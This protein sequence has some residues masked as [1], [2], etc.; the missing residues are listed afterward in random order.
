[1]SSKMEA[2]T[3]LKYQVLIWKFIGIIPSITQKSF[4]IA[5]F[6]HIIGDFLFLPTLI[7]GCTKA[8]NS[9]ELILGLAYAIP[10]LCVVF[11]VVST[12]F[13]YQQII[14]V[15]EILDCLHENSKEFKEEYESIESAIQKSQKLFKFICSFYYSSV[16]IMEIL[17]T[18]VLPGRNLMAPMWV[19]FIDWK[20]SLM[21]YGLANLFQYIGIMYQVGLGAALDTEPAGNIILMTGYMQFL[22]KRVAKLGWDQSKSKDDNYK[23]LIECISYHG[24]LLKLFKEISKAISR[25]LFLLYFMSA[26]AQC[27]FAVSVIHADTQTSFVLTLLL[28][29]STFETFVPCLFGDNLHYESELLA[30]AVADCNWMDQHQKFKKDLIFFTR[31][32]QKPLTVLAGG[33][34]PCSMSTFVA[35]QKLAYSIFVLF[36]E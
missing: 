35:L 34:I 21:T 19:P 1:M 12:N 31:N 6:V 9:Q 28:V 25:G 29:S 27:C 13:N 17:V 2:L 15:S 7:M 22:R 16:T 36:K 4:I 26:L 32:T 14:K 5:V 3:H 30:Y 10:I 23:E 20:Q 24:T 18:F 33:H 8:P 11:R